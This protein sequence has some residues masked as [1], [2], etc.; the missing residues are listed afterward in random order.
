V[1]RSFHDGRALGCRKPYLPRAHAQYHPVGSLA[2]FTLLTHFINAAR[3]VTV[4]LKANRKPRQI[5]FT[6]RIKLTLARLSLQAF[7][8]AVGVLAILASPAQCQQGSTATTSPA[9]LKALTLEQLAELEVMSPGKKQEKLSQVAAAIDVI[10]QDEIRRSGVR[11]IP[12]ALRLVTGLQVAKFNNGSWPISA[13]GFATTAANKIQVFMDGRSLY[14]PLF[15]GAFWDMQHTVIEDIDRIEVIRGPAATLWGGNAVNAVINIITKSASDTKGVLLVA[16]GGADERGFATFRYGGALGRSAA[17]RIYGS[18]FNRDSLALQN[19]ADAKDPNQIGQGG[20]RIDGALT[21]SDHVT[22]QGDLYSGDAGILNRPDIGTHGGN[23][24]A[25]WTHQFKNG[26]ELQF[27][28]YYDR[29]SRL[30][31]L[32]IDEI[33]N[34]YDVDFQYRVQAGP[35]HDLVWGVGYRGSKNQTTPQPALFFEPPGRHLGLFNFFAQDEIALA[36]EKLHLIVGSKFENYTYSGWNAQPSVRLVWNTT[37]RQSLWTAVSRAVRIPTQFD[38]DLRIAAGPQ[39]LI[40]GS[41]DFRSEGLTAYEVGYRILPRPKLSLA[42]STYYNFYG[43]LRS[44]EAVSAGPFPVILG[45]KLRGR[46]YGAEISARY[47]VLPWWRLTSGYSNL[48]KNLTLE[49]GSTDRTGGLQE[50]FDPRNQVSLRSN[51]DLGRNIELDFWARHVSALQLLAPPA[52]P[53][54]SVFDVRLGWR[55]VE[56]FELSVVGRNL[57]ERRHLEF[58]PS[59]ELVRRAA[60]VTAVWRF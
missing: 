45:N 39:L 20:F 29:T 22:V 16:G 42:L 30:V 56:S 49:P 19:G 46:T 23:L 13:R 6:S 18:Y 41:A 2:S 28:T 8:L 11:N 25:R 24:L 53:A 40:R 10:T 37:K 4:N 58:G 43:H 31:P 36:G 38:R 1:A 34:M 47:Q 35:R 7:T 14:S 26:S 3:H 50:G 27:Q 55:P 21:P 9:M 60:Y 33:R 5:S 52:V 15:G 57:P 51:M 59:G 12:E 32:Q 17:Y 44:Q 54:Y 48:Q